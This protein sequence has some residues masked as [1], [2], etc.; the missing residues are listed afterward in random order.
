M[1]AAV[2]LPLLDGVVSSWDERLQGRSLLDILRILS[3]F[4]DDLDPASAPSFRFS[5]LCCAL[6]V[7]LPHEADTERQITNRMAGLLHPDRPVWVKTSALPVNP[8]AHPCLCCALRAA[9]L[10][11]LHCDLAG[12]YSVT[13]CDLRTRRTRQTAQ[14]LV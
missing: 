5:C 13:Q 11:P 6:N 1:V 10:L 9:D 2:Y 14:G 3:Q 12:L 4:Y 8:P 7:A